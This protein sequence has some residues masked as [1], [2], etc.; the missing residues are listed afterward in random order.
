MMKRTVVF[1]LIYSFSITCLQS[2][3]A[4][5]DDVFT[6][7]IMDVLALDAKLGRYAVCIDC[8]I[9]RSKLSSPGNTECKTVFVAV[10]RDKRLL[11]CDA[12]GE[13]LSEDG[14]EQSFAFRLLDLERKKKKEYFLGYMDGPQYTVLKTEQFPESLV[15]QKSCS[16]LALVFEGHN[17]QP[18]QATWENSFFEFGDTFSPERI[19]AVTGDKD[20][21]RG[22][23]RSTNKMLLYE[24][25]SPR[26]SKALISNA[27][28]YLDVPALK[29]FDPRSPGTTI[30]PF[31]K[32]KIEWRQ[33]GGS[34]MPARVQVD[35]DYG[36][37]N[38]RLKHS[39]VYVV[40]W[41]FDIPEAVFDPAD[42]QCD[43]WHKS[44]LEELDYK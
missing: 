37:T 4:D 12:K 28:C 38:F 22:V 11:R 7:R 13:F 5:D 44:H 21:I 23:C 2:T 34:F 40:R 19:I 27:N 32:A 15:R 41:A 14:V 10:D 8:E 18:G 36:P 35:Y 6:D 31:S 26:N 43:F 33:V 17:D 39:I 3:W 16:P 29:G 42:M 1:L 25:S 30:K 24:I 20:S 9:S